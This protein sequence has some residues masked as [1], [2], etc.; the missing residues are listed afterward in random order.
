MLKALPQSL[1]AGLAE[2][3]IGFDCTEGEFRK[4]LDERVKSLRLLLSGFYD[5]G[6]A[7]TAVAHLVGMNINLC[8][9]LLGVSKQRM[10]KALSR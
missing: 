6:S 4:W 9:L 2:T 8:A 7:A 3:D 5:S 1:V 10:N